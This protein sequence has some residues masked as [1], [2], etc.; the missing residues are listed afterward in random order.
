MNVFSRAVDTYRQEGLFAFLNKSLG[1]IKKKIRGEAY[2][3]YY[4]L[5]A[6]VFGDHIINVD[7]VSIDTNNKVFSSSMKKTLRSKHYESAES[8]LINNYIRRNYS[9]VDLGAGIGYTACLV[10]NLTNNSTYTIAVE[11]NKSLIPVIK[12]TRELNDCS[13]EILN[14]AYDPKKESIEFRIANDFWS[15]SQYDR[16]DRNQKKEII[17]SI[18]IDRIIKKYQINPPLQLIIDIEGS[19]H[20][21]LVSEQKVLQNKVSMIIFEHHEFTEHNIK[22]YDRLLHNIGF[23]YIT[24]QDDVYVYKNNNI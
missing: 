3:K 12:R 15:S 5:R 11:A 10:D 19:E 7:G 8:D 13:F 4:T 23:K 16:E 6:M 21:L 20:N 2:Q 24:S 9:T 1:F 17:N 22:Y 18:S 14:S